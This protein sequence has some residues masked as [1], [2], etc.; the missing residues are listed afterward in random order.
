MIT[1]RKNAATANWT[2]ER[3]E[4][5][6]DLWKAGLSCSLIAK[7]L[8]GGATKNSVI[9]KVQRLKLPGRM[10]VNQLPRGPEPRPGR[11]GPDRTMRI[12]KNRRI[13]LGKPLKLAAPK[14]A[15]EKP[16]GEAWEP[17]PG[18]TLVSLIDLEPG[19]CRWPVGN[20]AP[21]LF[22]G[23]HADHGPYC[24]HHHLWSIGEGTAFERGAVKAA[25]WATTLERFVPD[26][27]AA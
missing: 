15:K 17:I 8:G 24:H 6:T 4:K 11:R 2:D 10:T 9:G 5:L 23:A 21:H 20:E 1:G 12:T 26:R 19:Q 18:V 16:R 3:V 7:E 27:K 13:A 22:C 14:K 25:K